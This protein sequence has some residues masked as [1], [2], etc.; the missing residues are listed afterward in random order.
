[1]LYSS[2]AGS[3]LG[4]QSVEEEGNAYNYSHPRGFNSKPHRRE[5]KSK[6]RRAERGGIGGNRSNTR[7]LRGGGRPIPS[8]WYEVRQWMKPGTGLL[9]RI[10]VGAYSWMYA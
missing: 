1:M 5:R 9:Q 2:T 3:C 7:N 10:S 6:R 4:R 8:G